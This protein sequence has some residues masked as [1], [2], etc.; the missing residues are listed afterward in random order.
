MSDDYAASSRARRDFRDERSDPEVAPH[1][2]KK[3]TLK[4]CRGKVGRQHDWV[5]LQDHWMRFCLC[6]Q[7][8]SVCQKK[9]WGRVNC[10]TR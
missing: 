1:V 3:N 9:V 8:C 10:S 6:T 7:V 2:S 5:T 4:W